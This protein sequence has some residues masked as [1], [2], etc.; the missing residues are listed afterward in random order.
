MT[1]L[2][3]EVEDC[4][5][6]KSLILQLDDVSVS[7]GVSVDAINTLNIMI[8]DTDRKCFTPKYSLMLSA[9]LFYSHMFLK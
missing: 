9:L 4:D 8:E 1:I 3:N 7:D 2:D 6:M 5:I